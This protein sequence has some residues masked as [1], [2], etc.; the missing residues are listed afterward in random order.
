VAIVNSFIIPIDLA[1]NPQFLNY[2][3]VVVLDIFIDLIF[4]VDIILGF[5]TTYM[6]KRGKEIKNRGKIALTYVKTKGFYCDV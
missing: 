4:F 2:T 6:D 5:F 1:F 3:A